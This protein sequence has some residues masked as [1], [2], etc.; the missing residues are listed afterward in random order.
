MSRT[1]RRLNARYNLHWVLRDTPW[2]DG[3]WQRFVLD[4]NSR[5]GKKALARYFSDA[6]LGD[7][8]HATAPRWYRRSLNHSADRREEQEL[9]R[10]RNNPDTKV[11]LPRRVSDARGYW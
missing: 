7:T 6:G 9:H 10:W 4:P 1:T 11:G 3:Q 2:I 5:A 8:A